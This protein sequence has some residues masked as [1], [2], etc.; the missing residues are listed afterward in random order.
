M[1]SRSS[2]VNRTGGVLFAETEVNGGMCVLGTTVEELP[3]VLGYPGVPSEM[4]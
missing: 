1:A 2:L 4:T 3:Q